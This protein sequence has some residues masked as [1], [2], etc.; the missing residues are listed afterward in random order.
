MTTLQTGF[1]CHTETKRLTLRISQLTGNKSSER[2]ATLKELTIKSFDYLCFMKYYITTT[3]NAE[4]ICRDKAIEKGC[5]PITKYW[6]CRQVSYQTD[7]LT[8]ICFPDDEVVPYATI[9]ELPESFLPPE[10]QP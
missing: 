3:A 2:T 7:F 10:D 5:G 9:S 4:Q 8:A 1:M 6:W